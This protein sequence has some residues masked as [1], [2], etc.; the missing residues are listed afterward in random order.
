MPRVVRLPGL[1]RASVC[2]ALQ[3][4]CAVVYGAAESE[5]AL[6]RDAASGPTPLLVFPR[7]AAEH[8]A[9]SDATGGRAALLE[10]PPGSVADVEV[11]LQGP[12]VEG[13]EGRLART[14]ERIASFLR[15]NMV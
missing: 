11:H 3:L 12:G 8:Q 5:P 2:T 9:L 4:K 14:V 13:Y 6:F 7:S 15:E 10:D 1:L